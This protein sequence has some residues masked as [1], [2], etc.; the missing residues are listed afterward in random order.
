MGKL[1]GPSVGPVGTEPVLGVP[2][3][4]VLGPLMLRFRLEVEQAGLAAVVED[5]R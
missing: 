3:G 5:H 1:Q 4:T 2:Q